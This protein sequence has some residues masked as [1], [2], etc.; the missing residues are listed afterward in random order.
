[1]PRPSALSL[2]HHTNTLLSLLALGVGPP[3]LSQC[4]DAEIDVLRGADAIIRQEQPGEEDTVADL[5]GVILEEGSAEVLFDESANCAN[6]VVALGLGDGVQPLNDPTVVWIGSF[7]WT[8][9]D[10]TELVET[11][12]KGL[13][14]DV[15]CGASISTCEGGIIYRGTHCT[16]T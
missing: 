10:K 13:S 5:E 12:L 6:Q 3:H 9:G 2:P 14:N 15:V 16:R 8:I 11:L 4:T 7:E 1:M